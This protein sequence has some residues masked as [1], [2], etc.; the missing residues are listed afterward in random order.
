[1][2]SSLLSR[3]LIPGKSMT[4]NV[5]VLF[6]NLGPYHHSRLRAAATQA[7]I[8]AI[9][10]FGREDTYQWRQTLGS[11]GFPRV[12]LFESKAK[13]S[14]GVMRD[15]LSAALMAAR[16]EVVAIPGWSDRIPLLALGWCMKAGVPAVLM[17]DSSAMDERRQFWRERTKMRIVACYSAALAA[18]RRHVNYLT[19]LGMRQDKIAVGYDVVDNSYFESG[20]EL[21]RRD[22]AATRE[23]LGLPE[24]Y[25]LTCSRFIAKKNQI[26]LVEAYSDYRVRAGDDA[27]HLVMLG[28]GPLRSTITAL[29]KR[30]KLERHVHVCGFRQYEELPAYYGLASGFVHASDSEQWG[31]V[32][33]E[34]M[35][36]GLPVLLSNRCGCA[37]E[38]VLNGVNG[39]TFNPH[40]T[41]E[42]ASLMGK[43]AGEGDALQEMGDASRRIVR[44]WGLERFA[45]GLV[46][47][48]TKALEFPV[49]KASAADRLLVRLLASR[50]CT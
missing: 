19:A 27:W 35:A 48:T 42:L 21:A 13:M 2:G 41:S 9:E 5:V 25:F 45:C 29:V 39:Y 46:E 33:N 36:S 24:K 8:V 49:R 22:G 11:C 16:P 10:A 14:V 4:G 7:P 15:R 38:L 34:A 17:T 44:C 26:R 37:P 50:L 23:R 18:G 1:M 6:E 47:A 20:A 30:L 12:T 28:D 43:L 32:V 40:R 31:L 3:V